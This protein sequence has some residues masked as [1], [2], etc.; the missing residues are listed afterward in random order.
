MFNFPIAPAILPAHPRHEEIPPTPSIR[1]F[2]GK[3]GMNAFLAKYR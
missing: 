1:S 2:L 3:G